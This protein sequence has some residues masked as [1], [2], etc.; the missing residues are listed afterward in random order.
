MP[1]TVFTRTIKSFERDCRAV[2]DGST[3]NARAWTLALGHM[4]WGDHVEAGPGIFNYSNSPIFN[5]KNGGFHGAG[6]GGNAPG[7][8]GAVGTVLR[9]TGTSHNFQVGGGACDMEF[10]DFALTSLYRKSGDA[11]EIFLGDRSTKTMFRR[12]NIFYPNVGVRQEAGVHNH[13]ER[14]C[15]FS[16]YG[17]A[18]WYATGIQGGNRNEGLTL[19]ACESYTPHKRTPMP[20]ATTLKNY[21]TTS[22]FNQSDYAFVSGWLMECYTGGTKGASA[23]AI[24]AMTY[25]QDHTGVFIQDGSVTWALVC[26]SDYA[27]ADADSWGDFLTLNNQCRMVEGIHAVRMRNTRPG[28]SASSRPKKLVVSEAQSDHHAG[29]ACNIIE[30]GSINIHDNEFES[31]RGAGVYLGS[32]TE[33]RKIS[34]NDFPNCDLGGIVTQDAWPWNNRD[35]VFGNTPNDGVIA[36]GTQGSI[37][38]DA[39][40]ALNLIANRRIGGV[41]YQWHLGV[42][43]DGDCEVRQDLPNGNIVQTWPKV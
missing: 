18:G 4:A 31:I 2:G 20:E 9:H 38:F 42:Q 34:H 3:D 30:C 17:Y 13:F 23:P 35:M 12:I 22:T 37:R 24:P 33:N 14:T 27:A 11:A 29:H 7:Y 43:D 16:P 15:V 40:W 36:R 8:G 41:E 28:A 5:T 32:G 21:A 19:S 10:S 26:K 6:P 1:L 25:A 39:T